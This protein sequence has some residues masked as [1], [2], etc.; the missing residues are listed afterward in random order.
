[1][2]RR[3]AGRF[4]EGVAV[5]GVQCV[6]VGLLV[7]LPSG[8]RRRGEQVRGQDVGFEGL[9]GGG[10]EEGGA[11]G[12]PVEAREDGVVG[13]SCWYRRFAKRDVGEGCC[14]YELRQARVVA[15]HATFLLV[16]HGE[17]FGRCLM[18]VSERQSQS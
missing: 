18:T 5:V 12:G 1:M 8:G 16:V 2:D 9:V 4:G 3:C 7:V 14:C 13:G 10:E 11:V 6:V 15:C 17:D